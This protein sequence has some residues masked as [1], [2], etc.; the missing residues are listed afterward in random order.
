MEVAD[1]DGDDGG[2]DTGV[3]RAD[4]GDSGGNTLAACCRCCGCQWRQ[5]DGGDRW[6][7]LLE[8]TELA[9]CVSGGMLTEV[10][11]GG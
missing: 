7:W 4:A 6:R 8:A 11:G 9:V 1:G 5:A 10:I 3:E 2:V